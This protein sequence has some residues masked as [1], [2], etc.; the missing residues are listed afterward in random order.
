M[1]VVQGLADAFRTFGWQG[2]FHGQLAFTLAILQGAADEFELAFETS[3]IVADPHVHAHGH[4][5]TPLEGA[6]LV[7]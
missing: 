7:L 1:V 6:V 4:A 2:F 5:F 3:A